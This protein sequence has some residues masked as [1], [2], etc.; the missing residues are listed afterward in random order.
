MAKMLGAY[1]ESGLRV[2]PELVT[3]I[4]EWLSSAAVKDAGAKGSPL[5]PP[6]SAA[7]LLR[8]WAFGKYPGL[9]LAVVRALVG[10]AAGAHV[11][12][13]GRQPAQ[14]LIAVAT[15]VQHAQ[16]AKGIGNPLDG[17]QDTIARWAS[18]AIS[19]ARPGGFSF[20]RDLSACLWALR[21]LRVDPDAA[22]AACAVVKVAAAVPRLVGADAPGFCARAAPALSD[23]HRR[24][25]VAAEPAVALWRPS[26]PWPCGGRAGRAR[27]VRPGAPAR[28]A[29][30]P[31][32]AWGAGRRGRLAGAGGGHRR[33]AAWA[34]ASAARPGRLRG[35][36]EPA[37]QARCGKGQAVAA[38]S[39]ANKHLVLV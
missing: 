3:C 23:W 1:A 10:S 28:H 29:R 24:G 9:P 22:T 39:P 12:P 6:A 27:A 31:P 19:A 11:V 7:V 34:G 21:V 14:V 36:R 17:L 20:E 13:A 30:R 5:G 8:T 37:L 15:L 25:L 18:L 32:R 33:A 4:T 35:C 38:V 16:D 26:R 2:R